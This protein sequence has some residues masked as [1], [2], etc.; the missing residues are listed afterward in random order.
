LPPKHP[1]FDAASD[2]GRPIEILYPHQ[3]ITVVTTVGLDGKEQGFVARAAHRDPKA[4]LYWHLDDRYL[5][6]TFGEHDL[7][8]HPEPGKHVLVVLD[9]GGAS[10]SV[11]FISR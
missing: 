2:S 1:G 3:G 9:E 7:M 8:L 5:G 11:S 6:Q 10:R 4:V